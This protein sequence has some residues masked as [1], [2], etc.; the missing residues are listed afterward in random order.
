MIAG[1][2]RYWSSSTYTNNSYYAWVVRMWDGYVPS[3]SKSGN[4]Y[5]W[6]VRAGQ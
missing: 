6:P 4:G 5:V 2:Y 3:I 1:R